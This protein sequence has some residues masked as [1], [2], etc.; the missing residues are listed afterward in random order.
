M[1]GQSSIN[2]DG[3]KYVE[4]PSF[5][6]GVL[7][8]HVVRAATFFGSIPW[9]GTRVGYIP[10]AAGPLNTLFA[11]GEELVS[12]RLARGS[13][14]RDLFYYLVSSVYSSFW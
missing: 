6:C 9:L 3:M 7:T 14:S 2:A 13:D 5:L 1:C 4:D 11:R 8:P 12:K 10:G